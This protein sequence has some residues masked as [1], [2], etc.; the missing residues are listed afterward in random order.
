MILR[1]SVLNAF[2][3]QSPIHTLNHLPYI[4]W[5]YSTV[6]HMLLGRLLG[7]KLH[8]ERICPSVTH[9]HTQSFALYSLALYF[10]Q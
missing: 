8:Y 4:P 9:P 10:L 5:P 6:N 1:S 2:V 7:A 3:H